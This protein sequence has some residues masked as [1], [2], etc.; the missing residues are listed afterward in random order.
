MVKFLMESGSGN[1]VQAVV[2]DNGE[3]ITRPFGYS[4]PSFLDLDTAGSAKNFFKPIAGRQFVLTGAVISGN[5]DI[6]PNG[7]ITSIYEAS[8]EDSTTVDSTLIEV[9]VPKGTVLP[10]LVPNVVSSEGAFINGKTD[11]NSVRIALYGYFV[12]ALPSDT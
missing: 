9:E 8:A 1:G 3:L 11:D 2:S 7:A 12:P 10:F 6:G 5:R 4:I